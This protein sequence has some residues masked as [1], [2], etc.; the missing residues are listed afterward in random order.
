MNVQEN[1]T[2]THAYGHCKCVALVALIF[3]LMDSAWGFGVII[4]GLIPSAWGGFR[5]KVVTSM[6]G[7]MGIGF[8]SREPSANP[9]LAKRMC[10]VMKEACW[11]GLARMDDDQNITRFFTNITISFHTF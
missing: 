4:G 2:V 1:Y 3:G 11:P 10:V 7:I 8:D 6:L 9:Y 5:R